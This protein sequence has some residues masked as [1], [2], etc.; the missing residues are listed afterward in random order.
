MVAL[1]DS[2]EEPKPP[3]ALSTGASTGDELFSLEHDL[4]GKSWTAFRMSP[5]VWIID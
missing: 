5:D 4:K 1:L 2:C 3:C